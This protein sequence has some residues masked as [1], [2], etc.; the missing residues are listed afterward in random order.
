MIKSSNSIRVVLE[1]AMANLFRNLLGNQL[2]FPYFDD[3]DIDH[4]AYVH[5]DLIHYRNDHQGQESGEGQTKDD[6]PG[7]GSP[8]DHH[9]SSKIDIGFKLPE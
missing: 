6:R 5:R 7:D 9:I 4:F 2:L 8:K 1:T 3:P